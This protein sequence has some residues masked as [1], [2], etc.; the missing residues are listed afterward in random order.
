MGWQIDEEGYSNKQDQTGNARDMM[1]KDDKKLFVNPATIVTIK[2]NS[3]MEILEN[4]E[5][6]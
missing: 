4:S 6:A 3:Y 5:V 2:K 1:C